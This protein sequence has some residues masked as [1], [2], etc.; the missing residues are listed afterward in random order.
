MLDDNGDGVLTIKEIKDGMAFHKIKLTDDEWAVFLKQID[1]NSD[2][3]LT[4]EEWIAV[5]KPRISV[6][7]DYSKIMG[8]LKIDDPL[9]LEE[10]VLDL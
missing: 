2:G 8:D 3:V 7:I 1:S 10:K 5:M 6:A 9:I 4:M